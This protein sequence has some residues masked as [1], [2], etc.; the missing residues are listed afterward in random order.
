M[1]DECKIINC[2]VL[3]ALM[4]IELEKIFGKQISCT[5]AYYLGRALGN[6]I[7]NVTRKLEYSPSLL[8]RVFNELV[9]MGI[10]DYFS[11]QKVNGEIS[12]IEF[13]GKNMP[14]CRGRAEYPIVRGLA[15][16]L[17]ENGFFNIS[18]KGKGRVRIVMFT[19]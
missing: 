7:H 3:L 13:S 10:V 5:I 9:K 8:E 17:A 12:C 18:Y 14:M 15:D 16:A 19:K 2:N 6:A 1:Y 11:L 4:F